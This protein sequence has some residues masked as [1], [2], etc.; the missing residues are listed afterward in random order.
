MQG[1]LGGLWDK[2][3]CK[4]TVGDSRSDLINVAPDPHTNKTACLPQ[5]SRLIYFPHPAEAV[6]ARS[7]SFVRS[8]ELQFT[9]PSLV[10][11]QFIN[12]T[13]YNLLLCTPQ[14]LILINCIPSAKARVYG[15]LGHRLTVLEL[16]TSVCG[17]NTHRN[18]CSRW[19]EPHPPVQSPLPHLRLLFLSLQPLFAGPDF[20]FFSLWGCYVKQTSHDLSVCLCCHREGG[21]KGR[22]EFLPKCAD[23]TF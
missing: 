6:A 9:G 20:T 1:G 15:S 23:F 22:T 3:A 16:C 18:R 4:T 5:F 10:L 13:N 19:T 11:S 17:Q 12:F 7:G 2:A 21:A 14:S 8:R